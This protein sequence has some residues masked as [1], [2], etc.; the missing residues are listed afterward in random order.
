MAQISHADKEIKLKIVYYG[1]ALSGKTTNLIF[2][3]QVLFPNQNVK[4]FSINTGD[5]RTLFFDLLPLELGRINGYDLKL[6]LFTVPG[7]VRYNQTRRA[8]LQ[9]A[10][11]VVFVAD[12]QR[13]EQAPNRESYD[14]MR[15]NLAANH[16][17]PATVPL[18]LQYNK[19]DLEEILAPKEMDDLL[20]AS[21]CPSFGAI[22]ITGVGV[23]QT[24]KCSIL[25]VLDGFNRNFPDF[26]VSEIE[27]KIDRSFETVLEAYQKKTRPP[28]SDATLDPG[29]DSA[30]RSRLQGAAHNIKVRENRED[31]GADELL[32]KAVETNIEIAELYTE[33]NEVKNLLEKKNRELTITGQIAQA[34]TEPFEPDQLPRMIFKS[35]LLTFQTS[36]GTILEPDPASG[37]LREMY[38]SGFN[39][40]PL[41]GISVAPSVSV[42]RHL[43]EQKRPFGFNVFS[44]DPVGLAGVSREAFV[45]TLKKLKVMAFMSVPICAS[46]ICY[47]LMNVYQMINE[48]SVLKAYGPEDLQFFG[49]L[50]NSVSLAF[51]R[52]LHLQRVQEL[53]GQMEEAVQERTARLEEGIRVLQAQN[54][55]YQH[56]LTKLETLLVPVLRMAKRQDQVLQ[57]F[58]ADITKPVSAMLTASKIVEKF[59]LSNQETVDRFMGV[60]REESGRMNKSLADFDLTTTRFLEKTDFVRQVFPLED[61]LQVLREIYLPVIQMKELE[62]REEIPADLP[63]LVGDKGKFQFVLHQ[64]VENALQFT[65]SGYLELKAQFNPIF[66]DRFLLVSLTDSGTGI[67]RAHLPRIFD[68]FFREEGDFG[69]GNVNYGLGLAFC[70]EIVEHNGGRIWAK[71]EEGIGS[72]FF[73]ELPVQYA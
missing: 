34:L 35:I 28:V 72:T 29:S 30:F 56:R 48:S 22:A 49:R 57:S 38:V 43:F 45:E 9:K 66:N 68:R 33:L 55:D 31:I 67:Q 4:L 21:G 11:G 2:V 8:V 6:Q 65:T 39:R 53:G 69:A 52:R 50:G 47:G 3:H 73:V 13:S 61:L 25:Q 42:A 12:S 27:D 36:H 37:Q 41:S 7:Q 15:E 10:D 40:D 44:F 62:W 59:G 70:K 16:L 24:L 71:S 23:L 20:N 58:K 1:P 64:L 46:G 32:D 63:L 51:E 17:D 26:P 14:N 19:Q 5:D 18:V 54:R 60:I